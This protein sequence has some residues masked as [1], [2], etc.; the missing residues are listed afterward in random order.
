M[1]RHG[2]CL[3]SMEAASVLGTG[4]FY[5]SYQRWWL[6]ISWKVC[7]HWVVVITQ[8]AL[9]ILFCHQIC[10]WIT[11]RCSHFSYLLRWLYKGTIHQKG[12]RIIVT[13]PYFLWFVDQ[14]TTSSKAR[15]ASCADYLPLSR[16]SCMISLLFSI[17]LGLYP[18]LDTF[19]ILNIFFFVNEIFV[20]V[21]F[22]QLWPSSVSF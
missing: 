3:S 1:S 22:A 17:Y 9:N 16:S 20:Y 6:A 21:V 5:I 19:V 12:R 8:M 11:R 15:D 13:F 10:H 14:L 4:K 18:L 7:G 2:V